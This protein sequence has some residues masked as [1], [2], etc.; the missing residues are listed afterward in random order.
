MATQ[1]QEADPVWSANKVPDHKLHVVWKHAR[2]SAEWQKKLADANVLTITQMAFMG[3]DED[4]FEQNILQVHTGLKILGTDAEDK[5][6]EKAVTM[7][8]LKAAWWD[9][10]GLWTGERSRLEKIKDDPNKI[11]EVQDG[12]RRNMRMS[13]MKNHPDD[14]LDKDTEPHE[15]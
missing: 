3:S 2:L 13:Y 14:K 4:K 15:S 6:F 10:R 9:A 1:G 12:D 5:R 7:T 11:P 8:N